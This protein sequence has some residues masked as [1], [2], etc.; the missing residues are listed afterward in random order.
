[1]TNN[2]YFEVWRENEDLVIHWFD[3]ESASELVFPVR[4]LED[5]KQEIQGWEWRYYD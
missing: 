3:G 4:K 1:M 2:A 5:L